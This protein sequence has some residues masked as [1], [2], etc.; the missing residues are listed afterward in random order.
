LLRLGKKEKVVFKSAADL[1][2]LKLDLHGSAP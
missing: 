2:G 1:V